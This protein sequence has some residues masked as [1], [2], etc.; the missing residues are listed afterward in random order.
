M[1]YVNNEQVLGIFLNGRNY[2][3]LAYGFGKIIPENRNAQFAY[4][5]LAYKYLNQYRIEYGNVQS[6]YSNFPVARLDYPVSG[7]FHSPLTYYYGG[8]IV[9]TK[10]VDILITDGNY[11]LRNALVY[12]DMNINGN[13]VHFAENTDFQGHNVNVFPEKEDYGQYQALLNYE[14]LNNCSN[15]DLNIE[16]R[17]SKGMYPTLYNCNNFSGNF[18]YVGNS[19]VK[20]PG[21]RGFLEDCKDGMFNIDCTNMHGGGSSA[22]VL[23]FYNFSGIQGCSNIRLNITGSSWQAWVHPYCSSSNCN[24]NTH[25]IVPGFDYMD[26]CNFKFYIPGKADVE[27]SA[28][29]SI[30]SNSYNCNVYLEGTNSNIYSFR[31]S[32]SGLFLFENLNNC[33]LNLLLNNSTGLDYSFGNRLNNCNIQFNNMALAKQ[34]PAYFSHLSNC[35]ING[36]VIKADYSTLIDLVTASTNVNIN[37]NASLTNNFSLLWRSSYINGNAILG[38]TTWVS[39]SNSLILNLYNGNNCV[40]HNVSNSKFR[41]DNINNVDIIG[42]YNTNF[43]L[44]NCDGY[45]KLYSL[46]NVTLIER[47]YKTIIANLDNCGNSH[48]YANT[49]RGLIENVNN[50][51]VSLKEVSEYNTVNVYNCDMTGFP[52]SASVNTENCTFRASLKWAQ[53]QFRDYF[54]WANVW[55]HATPRG[56]GIYSTNAG[57]ESTANLSRCYLNNNN[58]SQVTTSSAYFS[59][60]NMITNLLM[61]FSRTVTANLPNYNRNIKL[62]IDCHNLNLGVFQ[63]GPPHGLG[64]SSISADNIF[65]NTGTDYY[66][67]MNYGTRI[68]C[69]NFCNVSFS[70][71]WCRFS[72]NYQPVL[73]INNYQHANNSACNFNGGIYRIGRLSYRGGMPL[74]M[75]LNN[76]A[77]MFINNVTLQKVEVNNALLFVGSNVTIMQHNVTNGGLVVSRKNYSMDAIGKFVNRKNFAWNFTDSGPW[78][79]RSLLNFC[80]DV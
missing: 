56:D 17:F 59:N 41:L 65:C 1:F 79:W 49:V 75:Y 51:Y 2:D 27:K 25:F 21:F 42:A 61:Y 54:T 31:N 69:E 80:I 62:N 3:Y 4:I 46:D 78:G 33:N 5:N 39:H 68:Y 22:N 47:P 34:G 77:C 28:F 24:I 8:N 55:P 74:N 32:S 66:V 48:I 13:I 19:D 26:H 64:Y 11:A 23:N 6:G 57:L 58:A 70:P 35:N 7:V 15:F 63:S 9:P 72:D 52:G 45:S 76:G 40:F 53:T 29:Y 67:E 37:V 18:R 50:T 43:N 14:M 60:T 38:K 30:L 20:Y 71:V 16:T 36:S 73:L 10:E 12:N 44:Y